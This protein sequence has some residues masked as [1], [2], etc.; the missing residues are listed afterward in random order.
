[1]LVSSLIV[2]RLPAVA[3]VLKGV[4]LLIVH[5]AR[6]V[7]MK[8]IMNHLHVPEVFH[9]SVSPLKGTK[10]CIFFIMFV[11]FLFSDLS[12]HVSFDIFC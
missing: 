7:L 5:L 8:K 10:R 12:C 2:D 11:N 9:H 4:H 3:L 1:M 6:E